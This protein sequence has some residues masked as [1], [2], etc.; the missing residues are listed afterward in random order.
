MSFTEHEHAFLNGQRLARVATASPSGEPD[1]APVTFKVAADGRIEIDGMDN[2]KTLKWR[3]I[4]RSGR[5]A[6]VIDDLATLDPWRPRGIKIRGA[7]SADTDPDGRKVIRI[8]PEIIWSWGI[9][10]DAPKHFGGVIERR[11]VDTPR[12]A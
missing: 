6:I 1:V 11:E 4:T 3:N 5:A 8:R 10:P 9:N 12:P 2:P 7:A